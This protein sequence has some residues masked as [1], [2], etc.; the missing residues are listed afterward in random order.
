M[1]SR[2]T[3]RGV[4]KDP[5]DGRSIDICHGRNARQG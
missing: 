5:T 2:L 3:S 1:A 4:R